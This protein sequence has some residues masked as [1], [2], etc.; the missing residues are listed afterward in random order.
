M[1]E[2]QRKN[3]IKIF[4]TKEQ[5]FYIQKTNSEKEN[6]KQIKRALNGLIND[7]LTVYLNDQSI[8]NKGWD[9]I[10]NSKNK[11]FNILDIELNH[12][13]NNLENLPEFTKR[14]LIKKIIDQIYSSK[15]EK[16]LNIR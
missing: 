4:S 10:Y 8:Q 2:Y 13:K 12:K 3:L 6:K 9:I 5:D 7:T 11:K 1:E 15:I 14:E 16:I